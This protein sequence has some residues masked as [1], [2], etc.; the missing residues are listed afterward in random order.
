MISYTI[1]LCIEALLEHSNIYGAHNH[2]ITYVSTSLVNTYII[3][4]RN[5]KHMSVLRYP[6]GT[7]DHGILF[8]SSIGFTLT[9]FTNS[10]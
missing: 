6:K 1:S 8:L 10:K 7:I 4:A 3:Q 2:N 9:S 5:T